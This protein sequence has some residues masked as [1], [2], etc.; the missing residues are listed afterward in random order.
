[1]LDQL[2][3][4]PVVS[5]LILMGLIGALSYRLH[6]V[7]IS[8]LISAFVV[9]FTVWYTGGPAAFV[10]LLFY[11]IAAGIATKFKY[12][13]K[14]RLGIAQEAK[15]KRSWKNVFG[16]G[17]IPMLFSIGVYLSRQLAIQGFVDPSLAFWMFGGYVGAVSTTAADT[18]A[19][20][21]GVFSKSKPRLITN[22][23]RKVPTGTIGGVSLLGEAVA[24]LAGTF[25]GYI[26]VLFAVFARPLVPI[27]SDAQVFY[28][29]PLAI[30]T[31]F[32]GCNAD[33]LIGATLQNR[34]VC[35]ICGMITDKEFHCG[36]ETKYV[37]GF[38]RLSNFIVNFGS[39]GMGA[40]FGIVLGAG[41]FVWVLSGLFFWLLASSSK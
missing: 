12:K 18:L 30:I 27:S 34:Y 29:M 1:M 6:F 22:L 38:K 9:G 35:E 5:G 11:F 36:Y 3:S 41:F 39:S 2:L 15:G 40:T 25:I 32:A 20:E 8:G 7:D 21:L 17:T 13:A 33:S 10:I 31:A 23:R 19:S 37:G 16:S 28:L 26:L 4:H 24:L 14:A